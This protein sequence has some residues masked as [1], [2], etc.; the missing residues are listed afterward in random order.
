MLSEP[1]HPLPF[2]ARCHSRKTIMIVVCLCCT[3]CNGLFTRHLKGFRRKIFLWQVTILLLF[4]CVCLQRCS[5]CPWICDSLLSILFCQF[6][7]RWFRPEEPSQLRCEIRRLLQK[8][9]EAEPCATEL[10]GEPEPK[11]GVT[12]PTTSEHLPEVVDAATAKEITLIDV[13]ETCRSA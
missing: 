1:L 6:G 12:E 4:H 5:L 11:N 7:K 9:R 10:F 8:C 3:I 13:E 2:V